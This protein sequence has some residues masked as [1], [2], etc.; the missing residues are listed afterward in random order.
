M[1][2][3]LACLS[4]LLYSLHLSTLLHANDCLA[5]ID[6][7]EVG[8]SIANILENHAPVFRIREEEPQLDSIIKSNIPKPATPHNLTVNITPT[9]SE[10]KV[11]HEHQELIINRHVKEDQHTCPPFCIQP[12]HIENVKTVAELE[13]L[14]F[15]KVLKK[16]QSKLLIDA[17]KNLL[18][19]KQTIPGA[20]NI[21][22]NMLQD[23]SKYQKKILTLLGAKPRINSWD[24]SKVPTLLIF[25]NSE[26]E[27]QASDAIKQLLKLSYPSEKILYYR[28]GVNAWKRLGL[29]LYQ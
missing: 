26:E 13:V 22:H 6:K 18:Y 1:H 23:G 24:F 5:T 14:E 9:L 12:M 3:R 29:T 4:F 8:C 19:K 7:E 28:G 2:Q 27:S 11:E 10:I 15:I 20:T 16:K 17:R 25:G 21:P